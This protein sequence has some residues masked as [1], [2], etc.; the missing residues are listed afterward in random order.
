MLLRAESWL[1][2]RPR[3]GAKLAFKKLFFSVLRRLVDAALPI[4]S[5]NADYWRY[6][7]GEDFPQFLMPYAV[8]NRY[9]QQRASSAQ[10]GR[11]ALLAELNLDSSRP[12]IL[13]ASKLQHRKHC[14][15]LLE[16]YLSLRTE[17]EADPL[18]TL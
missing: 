2:D 13:F 1:R 6:Y 16:A 5:L 4:G 14:D 11:A 9:F 17:P 15:D 8:D 7:L 12:V 3:T 10:Q 18:P